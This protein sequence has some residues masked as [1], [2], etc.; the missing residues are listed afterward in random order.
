MSNTLGRGIVAVTG[1]A[2]ALS[3]GLAVPSAQAAAIPAPAGAD[4][5]PAAAAATYL[6]AQPGTDNLIKTYYV[7]PPGTPA[8]SYT[9]Y[10][11]TIDAGFALD[12]VGGQPAKLAA[13]TDALQANIGNYVF[14]GGAAAKL[15]SFLLAQGRSGTAVDDLV[16]DLEDHI[17]TSSPTTGRLVDPAPDPDDY[18]T[19][20]TQAYAVSALNNANST[21]APSALGFLLDQQCTAGFFRASFSAKVAS[22]QTCNGAAS[23]TPSIDTTGL[24]VLMLQDQKSKPVVS[25]G[26]TKALDW[27]VAQ[28]A[29]NGS[30]NSGNANSTGLAGWA[31]GAAGRTAAAAK[32]AGWLRSH[33]LANAGACTKYAAKDNGAVTVDDLGFTNAA[34]GPLD[35]VDN[36]VATRATTQALPALLWA[37]GGAAA[38]DTKLTGPTGFVPAGSAQSVG[39]SGAP[40]NTLCV[41][42]TGTP[43]RVVLDATGKGAVA[44]TL[45]PTTGKVTV[46]AV[47]AGGESDTLSVEGL[48]QTKLDVDLK[49]SKVAQGGKIAVKVSGLAAGETVTVLLGK[50]QV[51]AVANADGKVKVKL[52]AT[53]VG[54]GKVKAVGAFDNRKGKQAVTVTK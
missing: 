30:F 16:D 7:Y 42:S 51:E 8:Q 31:L 3:L 47:D 4:P 15:S 24:S 38:G 32:A 2:L 26:L 21:L 44:L 27:L 53:K 10:G 54:K 40:G 34:S 14:G 39:L 45:P 46:S 36:S 19:P 22:D 52:S 9:D 37:P 25:A 49:K 12:A 50:Q 41:T 23:P 5:A 6:A 28:Q 17:S 29:A 20:L 35:Q 18:N 48:A 43:T 33:Q 11:V 1:S 13:M